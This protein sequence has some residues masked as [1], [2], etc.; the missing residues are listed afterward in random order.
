RWTN[1]FIR[2][3][4]KQSSLALGE[5]FSSGF[6]E[7]T[8]Q[9]GW[10]ER[11]L[12]DSQVVAELKF[13]DLS[14]D[15]RGGWAQTQREAPHEYEFTYVRTNNPNDPLGSTYVN[16]LDRQRGS[17]KVSFSDLTEELWFGGVDLSYPVLDW[18]TATI[19]YAYSDTTRQSTRREFLFNAGGNFVPGVGALRPDYLLGDG[20]VDFY[21]IGLIEST[22]ADPAFSAGLEIHGAYGQL[23]LSPVDPISLDI[24]VRFETATQRVDPVEVFATP[25]NSASTTLLENEYWLPAATLTW[26]ATDRL[27]IARPQF[28]E[29]IFQTYYDPE[30]NRQYNG[31]PLLVDSTL[32]NAE[33]RAEYYFDRSNRVTL[34]GFYKDISNP[35]EAYSSFSDNNMAGEQAARDGCEL[36]LH[37]VR[38]PGCRGRHD[39]DLPR[40]HPPGERL[41]RR[42]RTA[43][44]PVRPH[45]QFSAFA[46]RHRPGAA[47]YRDGFLCQRA[48]DQPG[49]L[50]TARY[51]RKPGR[52]ARFRR[53]RRGRILRPPGRAEARSAQHPRPRLRGIPAG[54]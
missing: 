41:F 15:L 20:M 10:F 36:H 39:A 43:D 3:T 24:G 4:L 31:N 5:D 45:G 14:L 48:G 22:Q 25:T 19:G 40:R 37:Q 27:Q 51:S 13:G 9:T 34:A 52:A 54:G 47:I 53:P 44:G 16:I 46:G 6:S 35:I 26:E 18:A 33:A 23:R 7:A 30:T 32:I 17:G 49:H 38:N 12:L 1:L 50:R 42:W 29:L 21:K 8:Q 28:R 11:Q 2:D